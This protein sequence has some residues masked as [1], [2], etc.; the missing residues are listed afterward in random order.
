MADEYADVA[1]QFTDIF[2]DLEAR[3]RWHEIALRCV[4][5]IGVFGFIVALF[6]FLGLTEEGSGTCLNLWR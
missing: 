1:D 6:V 2:T 3:I 4:I 5:G